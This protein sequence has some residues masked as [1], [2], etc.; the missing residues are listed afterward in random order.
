MKTYPIYGHFNPENIPRILPYEWFEKEEVI[1][2]RGAILP[3]ERIVWVLREAYE[4]DIVAS[5]S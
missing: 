1:E 2:N 5:Q 3:E 4:G